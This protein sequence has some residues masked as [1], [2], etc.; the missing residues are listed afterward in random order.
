MAFPPQRPSKISDAAL[1]AAVPDAA[2][3][4]QLLQALGVAAYGG[5][6]DVIRHRLRLL[7]VHD[8]RFARTT[9]TRSSTPVAPEELSRAIGLADSYAQAARLLGLGEGTGAQ[10]RVKRMAQAAGLD[11]SHML[12]KASGRGVR[13][14]GRAPEPLETVLV[15]GRRV[16]TANLRQRL[17]RE[18]VLARV[19]AKCQRDEWQ[20]QP[21]PLELDHIN[22]ERSDN[23]LENL[24][25][26]CPNCHAQTS[27]YRGRNIGAPPPT[28]AP[29]VEEPMLARAAAAERRLLL[30]LAPTA[31][32]AGAAPP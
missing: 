5:N 26:L 12:G 19:C 16:H 30:V 6:Y 28:P 2:N 21:I 8:P 25:V 27:T 13:P 29:R 20:G 31:T 32:Y 22:G 1:L 10:R 7:G 11:T 15:R 23:R 9:R 3:L 24:R 18:G 14:G 17:L 4:R